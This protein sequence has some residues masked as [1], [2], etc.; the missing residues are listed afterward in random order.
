MDSG[1]WL[2]VASMKR[3]EFVTVFRL[4]DVFV[5]TD[6]S[7]LLHSNGTIF[8]YPISPL[9]YIYSEYLSQGPTSLKLLLCKYSQVMVCFIVYGCATDFYVVD[10]TL[11]VTSARKRDRGKPF[12]LYD[13]T[14]VRVVEAIS[15]KH[16]RPYLAL[17]N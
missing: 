6:T 5:T 13:T 12:P 1:L 15:G 2:T 3:W 14:A 8:G 9:Q 11:N 4:T 7:T 16:S 17:F 10:D